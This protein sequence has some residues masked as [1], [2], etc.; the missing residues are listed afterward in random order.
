MKK[1]EITKQ[2]KILIFILFFFVCFCTNA[3]AFKRIRHGSRCRQNQIK[4]IQALTNFE[5]ANNLIDYSKGFDYV[6]KKLY[7]DGFLKE[8]IQLEDE[9]NCIYRFQYNGSPDNID[10]SKYFSN[11]F[12]LYCEYHGSANGRIKPSKKFLKFQRDSEI[13]FTIWYYTQYDAFPL[14]AITVIV[15]IIVFFIFIHKK[16]KM[17]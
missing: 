6:T 12:D 11:Y 16:K 8:N 4:I 1:K 13:G 9:E 7:S 17:E 3:Y 14:I 2:N 10:D 15:I 5:E